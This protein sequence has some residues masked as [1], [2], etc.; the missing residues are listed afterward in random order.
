MGKFVCIF[1]SPRSGSTW[2][3][4]ILDSHP[5]VFY[6]HEPDIED[7]G[8]D[9]LPYWFAGKSSDGELDA[10]RRYVMRLMA[11]RSARAMGTRPFFAKDYRDAHAEWAWR[12]LVLGAKTAGL[13][14]RR[15]P[16]FFK[17]PGPEVTVI[18]AVSALGRL[19]RLI[20]AVPDMVPVLILRHPC[21]YALSRI[22]GH[23]RGLM[24][25]PPGMAPL[26]QTNSARRLGAT[27]AV[28]SAGGIAEQLAWDWLIANSE[29]WEAVT[30]KGGLV[31]SYDRLAQ[32]PVATA[33]Q[34]FARL[35]LS[36]QAGTERFLTRS[37]N[38][39]GR[40]YSVFRAPK[41]AP[42][43]LSGLS[44]RE[45][46][47]IRAIVCRVPLGQMAFA[48]APHAETAPALST[49]DQGMMRLAN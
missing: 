29:A 49:L 42:D 44:A 23:Q 40:Y 22:K 1:S 8:L 24:D 25:L 27:E 30:E 26:A 37:V 33:R 16:D 18:K 12:A 28:L 43:W 39:D 6:L 20:E 32:E 48:A 15:L 2:L 4:K 3:G 35:G 46:E 21:G 38:R 45:I 41:A 36:W 7:R 11:A 19:R 17:A 5:G 31:V 9:L 13:A 10:A 47:A 34:I 14:P